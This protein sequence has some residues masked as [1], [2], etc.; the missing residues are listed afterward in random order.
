MFLLAAQ[1]LGIGV[2]AP[3]YF[4]LHY[5]SSQIG[6]FK[7]LDHR[8]TN[9]AYTRTILPVMVFGYYAPHFIAY[10]ASSLSVRYQAISIWQ[11]FPVW[12]CSLQSIF[13]KTIIPAT[14]KKDRIHAPLRDLPIIRYTIGSLTLLSGVVW[15]YTVVMSPFSLRSIFVPQWDYSHTNWVDC[16]R[17]VLQYD[18]IFCWMSVILWL[19]YLF[20]DLKHAG[21][22]TQTWPKI[23]VAVG[24]V[25]VCFGPGAM[26]GL[27]WLWRE[28]IFATRRHKSAVVGERC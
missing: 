20:M 17:N 14:I 19:V 12:L 26:L 28:E 27:G 16:T 9:L 4:G 11:L 7:A 8:L 13:A 5:A 10:F 22:V 1:F 23:L 2:V 24:L 18:S 6:N 21:M 25:V 3:L 15:I